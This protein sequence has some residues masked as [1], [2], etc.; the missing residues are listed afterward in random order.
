M[1]VMLLLQGEIIVLSIQLSI[2]K[3]R[4]WS[5]STAEPLFEALQCS[6]NLDMASFVG[7]GC[8]R[9]SSAPGGDFYLPDH[10]IALFCTIS[11][12]LL[13]A[14]ALY[15]VLLRYTMFYCAI[16]CS[17]ALFDVLLRYS[18]CYSAI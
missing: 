4:L 15:D 12:G 11:F 5:F 9:F 18:M 2:V 3:N 10:C 14:T 8:P 6:V 17:T 1:L 7:F 13:C 16:R